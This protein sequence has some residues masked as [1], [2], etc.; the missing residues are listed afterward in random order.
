MFIFV[1][2]IVV[3]E[4]S[5]RSSKKFDMTKN[6]FNLLYAIKRHGLISYR[7]LSALSGTSLGYISEMVKVF[8]EKQYLDEQGITAHGIEALQPYKVKNA[9][10]MAAGRSPNF[11]PL[12]LETPKGLLVVKDEVLIERQIRQLQEAGIDEII[13]VLGYKKESFF[14]LHEKYGVT[15][16]INDQ[17][18]KK[19]NIETLYLAQRYIGNTY[20]CSSDN[21]FTE[22]VF[23]D[24]VYRPYYASV[25][26]DEQC[27]EWYMVPDSKGNIAKVK[28]TGKKGTIMLGHC[29]WSKEFSDEFIKLINHHHELHDYDQN[30]WEDLYAAN[31]KKLPP[32]EI[33]VYPNDVIFEFDSLED[34]RSFDEHYVRNTPSVILENICSVLSCTEEDIHHFK[35]IKQGLNNSSFMFEV[36]D[37]KYVY[38]HPAGNTHRTSSGHYEKDALALAKTLEIDPTYIYMNGEEGWKISNYI[39]NVRIPDY[40]DFE[41][42]KRVI[43]VLQK[44]HSHSTDFSRT[45]VPW[46]EALK[47]E[48]T[49]FKSSEIEM[50]DYD[51]LK[52]KVEQCYRKTLGDGIEMTFCHCDTYAQNWML[53]DTD[54]ILIDWEY[55]GYADP[56]CDV[57]TYI[58]DAMYDVPEAIR[59]IREY[60]RDDYS[61][62]KLFHYLAYVAVVS[63]YWFVWA[64]HQEAHGAVMGSS[65]YNW[66]LMAVRYSN[67][68]TKGM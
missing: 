26:V 48:H 44:L 61:E 51:S 65:L 9:V 54:T 19:N 2:Y 43:A 1:C 24:Y 56:G 7:K 57:G 27:N 59:F 3:N 52:A 41:D 55:A 53:N 4:R 49:I 40:S 17:Y 8:T 11:V 68:L 37:R 50:R 39:E 46:E 5:S 66:Y 47:L 13:V 33:K 29:Y 14:Y 30:L 16:I 36:F 58:M 63:F 35:L 64:L 34:L 45:F 18:N 62:A 10:I 12:S 60:C 21:Y 28:K 25:R 15:I 67:Y 31:I 22:N 23:T 32:M 6:E 20:I 38:R 42:S